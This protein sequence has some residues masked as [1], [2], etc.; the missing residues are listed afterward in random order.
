VRSYVHVLDFVLQNVSLEKILRDFIPSGM[1]LPGIRSAFDTPMWPTPRDA[2]R[3]QTSSANN[4]GG[5]VAA[6]R[7]LLS[8]YAARWLLALHDQDVIAYARLLF[9]IIQDISSCL[10]SSCLETS[11]GH[12]VRV[13]SMNFYLTD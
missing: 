10:E 6:R 8:R 11:N 3:A 9:E 12:E 7:S 13:T 4:S 5:Y 1:N 2:R